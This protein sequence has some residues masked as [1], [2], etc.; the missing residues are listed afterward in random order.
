MPLT[1]EQIDEYEEMVAKNADREVAA[2]RK[3]LGLPDS[4]AK[5]DDTSRP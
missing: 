2:Y 4:E 3:L 5:S 1:D